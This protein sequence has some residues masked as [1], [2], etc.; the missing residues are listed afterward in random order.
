MCT[1]DHW[2]VLDLKHMY[3]IKKIRGRSN[4]GGDPTSVDIYISDDTSNWGSAVYSGITTWQDT[5]SWAEV[6]ITDTIG[7]YINISITSTESGGGN[8][9]LEFGGIPTPMTILDVYGER[10]ATETYYF[11]SLDTG[12]QAYVWETNPSYMIDGNTSTYASTTINDDLEKITGNT[13]SGTDLGPISQVKLRAYGYYSSNQQDIILE[14]V[15]GGSY[16]GDRYFC[17][18]TDSAGWSSWLDITDDVVAP[19]T[20]TWSDV[21]SLDCNVY[22]GNG[23]LPFTLYCSKVEMCVIYKTIPKISNPSPA[24]GSIGVSINPTLSITVADPEGDAMNITWLSNSS[25]SW[26]VYGTNISVNNGTYYQVFS[27]ATVNGQ[28][29]YWKVNVSDTTSS[30]HLSDVYKFYTGY[31]SKIKNTGSTDIKGYLLM[32]VQYY[33]GTSEEWV[34]ADNTVNETNPRTINDGE[35]LALDNI[36]NG[37]VDT[38][39]LSDY[40]NGTYRV[41]AAFRDPNGNILIGDDEAEM[42]ATYEFT[43]TFK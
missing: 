3:N 37:L 12:G 29:W 20:W 43:V 31:Q 7:R 30:Y 14:P 15:F 9:Y 40:G 17:Q 8:D 28:W 34:I 26:Q 32:Q 42:V 23:C 2:L 38:S 6:D 18:I 13:C 24:D 22:A 16:P 25:S 27:N 21:A 39:D 36:F 4:T 1:E 10:M 41:Y 33:N 5:T 19:P 35:Q 11:D